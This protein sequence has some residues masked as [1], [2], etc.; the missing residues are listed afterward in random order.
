M[1]ERKSNPTPTPKLIKLILLI[2]IGENTFQK[3]I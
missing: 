2:E 1:A 3:E